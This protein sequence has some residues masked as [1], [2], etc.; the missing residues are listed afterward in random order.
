M[1][2]AVDLG[3]QIIDVGRSLFIGSFCPAMTSL[4]RYLEEAAYN[5]SIYSSVFIFLWLFSSCVMD[6]VPSIVLIACPSLR[7]CLEN[8]YLPS[9]YLACKN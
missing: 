4:S 8:L 7:T 6:I 9:A 5:I 2:S 3:F 1:A